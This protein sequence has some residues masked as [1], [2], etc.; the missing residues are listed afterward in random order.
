[1]AISFFIYGTT[2][3][4]GAISGA[5]SILDPLEKFTS[6]TATAQVAPQKRHTGY[7]ID[8]LEKEIRASSKPVVV[9]FGKESCAACLELEKLTFPDPSVKKEMRNFTFIKVDLTENSDDDKAI[10]NKYELFS[11]PNII[12]FDAN[13]NFLADKTLT[14]FVEPEVFVEHLREI[15][16]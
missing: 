4:V 6:A 5:T 16:K 12:F 15:A 11:T 10:L 1:L 3:F 13:N 8:R 9:D 14:G 2:L 7:S